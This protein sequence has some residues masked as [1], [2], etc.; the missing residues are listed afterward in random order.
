MHQN[1]LQ[2]LLIPLNAKTQVRHKLS[3]LVFYGSRIG[4]TR[5]R[6]IVR[7]RFAPRT[8]SN[9][10][11]DPQIKPDAKTEVWLNVTRCTFLE[12]VLVSHEHET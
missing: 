11:C 6:K 8:H 5:A 2:D 12:S 1:A 4:P 9:A 3:R 10:L 7:I